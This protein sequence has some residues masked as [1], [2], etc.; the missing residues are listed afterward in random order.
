MTAHYSWLQVKNFPLCKNYMYCKTEAFDHG[1]IKILTM[2]KLYSTKDYFKQKLALKWWSYIITQK[3]SHK[4]FSP[5]PLLLGEIALQTRGNWKR[6]LCVIVWLRCQ[7]QSRSQSLR[8]LDQRSE[9][10]RLQEQP[11][12]N[13]KGNNR[14]SLRSLYLW[15]TPEMV[16]PRVWTGKLKFALRV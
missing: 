6:R 3:L 16:A 4:C 8:S 1:S 9:N 15:R 12:W 14:I 7:V 11:F 5:A 10:E 13:N 2:K